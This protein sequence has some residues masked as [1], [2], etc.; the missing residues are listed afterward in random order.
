[1]INKAFS[2][3]ISDIRQM[4]NKMYHANRD[5]K[6][7]FVRIYEEYLNAEQTEDVVEKLR[8]LEYAI[9]EAEIFK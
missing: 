4:L 9:I 6:A 2:Y 1:M 3:Q 7:V 5:E 8:I